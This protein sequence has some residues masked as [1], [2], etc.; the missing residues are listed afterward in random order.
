MMDQEAQRYNF[1]VGLV[2]GLVVGV[3]MLF[4]A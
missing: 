4:L 1:Y 2:V 3:V